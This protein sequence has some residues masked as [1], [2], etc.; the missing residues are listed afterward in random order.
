MYFTRVSQ[1]FCNILLRANLQFKP[2]H[3]F[4]LLGSIVV[5]GTL[6]RCVLLHSVCNL[7]AAQ[8]IV[9]R[10]WIWELKLCQFE[11]AIRRLKQQKT[12]VEQ[13]LKAQLITRCFKKFHLGW[14]N[15]NDQ[16][17]SGRSKRVGPEA[18]LYSIVANPESSIRRVSGERGVVYHFRDIDKS[19]RSCWIVTRVTKIL[20]LLT[21]SSIMVC[22]VFLI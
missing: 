14:Q 17:R 2:W 1:K 8:M 3:V 19:T 22:F 13:N 12:F 4:I 15:L 10:C 16:A 21:L 9:R 11:F 18:E 20:Q 5:V 7:K 6:T